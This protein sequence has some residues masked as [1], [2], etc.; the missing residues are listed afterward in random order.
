MLFTRFSPL[1]LPAADTLLEAYHASPLS[2]IQ[3]TSVNPLVRGS[4]Y[5]HTMR[6]AVSVRSIAGRDLKQSSGGNTGRPYSTQSGDFVVR[7]TSL[8]SQDYSMDRLSCVGLSNRSSL[9]STQ[10]SYVSEACEKND[11]STI[12]Q[13]V[14]YSPVDT[15]DPEQ[16]LRTNALLNVAAERERLAN[17]VSERSVEADDPAGSSQ[18]PDD[19]VCTMTVTPL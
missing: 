6:R 9:I 2:S 5:G 14:T 16:T 15:Q 4:Y 1:P 18:D 3:D 11:P 17:S 10:S 8:I 13:P 12:G 19:E 7:P